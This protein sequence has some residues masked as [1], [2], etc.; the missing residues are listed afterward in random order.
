MTMIVFWSV[1]VVVS[2]PGAIVHN[3][4]RGL[5]WFVYDRDNSLSVIVI[6]SLPVAIE[7][8]FI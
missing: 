2:L 4:I 6:V 5:F 8:K 3:F 7:N 1:I